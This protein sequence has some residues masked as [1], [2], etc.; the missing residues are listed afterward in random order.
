MY[1]AIKNSIDHD[2]DKILY[3][4][5][6]RC[7]PEFNNTACTGS[8]CCSQFGWCGGSKGNNDQYS[9]LWFLTHSQI[10]DNLTF[11]TTLNI[12]WL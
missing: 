6:G 10:S 3:S 9:A 7:G 8:A 5:D 12:I 1:E 4:T 2:F 11:W